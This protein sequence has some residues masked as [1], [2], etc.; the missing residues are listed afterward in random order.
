MNIPSSPFKENLTAF[1]Q[2][3]EKLLANYDLHDFLRYE[4]EYEFKREKGLSQDCKPKIAWMLVRNHLEEEVKK[5]ESIN[6]CVD[7]LLKFIDFAGFTNEQTEI[8]V[9]KEKIEKKRNWHMMDLVR[10]FF[11]YKK[12]QGKFNLCITDFVTFLIEGASSESI[13]FKTTAQ[14][15]EFKTNLDYIKI[16][17]FTIRKPSED[18][19]NRLINDNEPW[20]MCKIS[21]SDD[22][23]SVSSNSVLQS[24]HFWIFMEAQKTR[25]RDPHIL[26][27]FYQTS[28]FN[29][30]SNWIEIKNDFKKL[31]LALRL[32]NGNYTGIRSIFINES[33]VYENDYFKPWIE[34]PFL[35]SEFGN[36]RKTS[37]S[38][39]LNSKE[40]V[41]DD[42]KGISDLFEKLTLYKLNPLEQI[43]RAL[44]NYF[45]A[46]EQNYPVYTFTELIMALETLLNEQIKVDPN[47]TLE[48]IKKIREADT[49]K[50]GQ[51]ILQKSQ[52][53]NSI[54]K[55]IK[56]LNQLLYPGKNNKDLNKFF[57]DEQ[58][59]NGC[60]Q[61]RNNLL[62]GNLNL[63][64]VEMTKKI[65]SL[66]DYVRLALLKTIDLRICNKLNCNKEDYFE[67]LNEILNT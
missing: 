2:D 22:I 34:D 3:C 1:F 60:Y 30:E 24:T 39:Y 16:Y 6:P 29:K 57:H 38:L 23:A 11:E 20:T 10:L 15:I 33:F 13:Y 9:G 58:K 48:L 53:K 61:I 5:L 42:I 44:D 56:M 63:D 4:V 21:N 41:L 51:K 35:N 37:Y 43:D 26:R 17:N 45:N 36:F 25:L 52:N 66:V 31:I 12:V 40:I 32:Y 8:L 47:E 62:H 55:S 59:K 67:R 54:H 7:S 18:E 19:I 14:L 46:F 65:P 28:E 50:K 27:R 49:D 64:S